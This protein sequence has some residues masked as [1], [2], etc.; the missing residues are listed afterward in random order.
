MVKMLPTLIITEAIK[1]I[2]MDKY[3]AKKYNE[4]SR[5]PWEGYIL[6]YIENNFY[7]FSKL[8]EDEKGRRYAHIK[9]LESDLL[10]GSYK[11]MFELNM[12]RS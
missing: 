3:E 10:D 4:K 2:Q 7:H 9:L 12:S 8:I 6:I 11:R 1:G 5:L